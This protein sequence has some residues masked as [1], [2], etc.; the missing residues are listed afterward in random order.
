VSSFLTETRP[1]I[2]PGIA[3]ARP[4]G[5]ES[6]DSIS[7]VSFGSTHA[8]RRSPPLGLGDLAIAHA[9]G[10]LDATFYLR[11]GLHETATPASKT[12]DCGLNPTPREADQ[13]T[14]FPRPALA[15]RYRTL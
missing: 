5:G 10:S 13:A 11:A 4:G 6:G 2:E 1:T 12:T 3:I 9:C 7:T 8:L 15:P 14:V